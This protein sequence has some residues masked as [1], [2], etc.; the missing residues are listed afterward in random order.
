MCIRD[1]WRDGLEAQGFAQVIDGVHHV[2]LADGSLYNVGSDG[3][4]KLPNV[5][6]NVD[7][8]TERHTFDVDFSNGVTAASIPEG[9]LFAIATGLDP[10]SDKGHGLFERAMA[11]ALNAA[12]SNA[13]SV[14]EVRA[15][16]RAMLGDTQPQDIGI[17]LEVLRAT[18]K[19]TEQEYQ[20][21]LHHLNKMYGTNFVPSDANQT[22]EFLVAQIIQKPQEDLTKGEIDLFLQL[23]DPEKINEAQRELEERLT[24]Q[25]E[26]RQ[27]ALPQARQQAV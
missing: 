2:T 20:V 19:I 7:G 16:Y 23:T 15:N 14:E 13:V 8:K 25:Q 27:T 5:G 9:H 3:G 26:A 24:K 10:T 4:H 11:Q 21:Y 18:S 17:R 12:T 22:K 1:S 6:L